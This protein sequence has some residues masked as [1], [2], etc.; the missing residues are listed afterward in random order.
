MSQEAIDY[1]CDIFSQVI[2]HEDWT[3]GYL[4]TNGLTSK[5]IAG[6]DFST[7]IDNEA[8]KYEAVLDALGLL[9][10]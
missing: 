7:F 10:A 5:F 3:E 1:W 8:A 2:E 6:A 4:D 9:A